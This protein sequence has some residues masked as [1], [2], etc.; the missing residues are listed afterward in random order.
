MSERKRLIE[1]LKQNCHCKDEDC[2]NCSSNGICFTHRE[3]DYLLE[4]DVIVPPVKVH[5]MVYIVDENSNE[6][7]GIDKCH[8][9]KLEWNGV[10]WA[11]FT[12]KDCYGYSEDYIGRTVF[13]TKEDAEKALKGGTE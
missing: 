1:L 13:L 6:F 8:V 11:I 7:T 4:N 3:A 9:S 2:S 5:D 12:D 10:F